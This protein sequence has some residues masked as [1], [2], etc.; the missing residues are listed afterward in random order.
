MLVFI[1]CREMNFEKLPLLG[2]K[3]NGG[4]FILQ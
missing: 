4:F 2:R 1:E 3:R